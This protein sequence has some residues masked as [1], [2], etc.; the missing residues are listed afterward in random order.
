M[1]TCLELPH[2]FESK[3]SPANLNIEFRSQPYASH[4]VCAKSRSHERKKQTKWLARIGVARR[5][6]A[7][8]PFVIQLAPTVGAFRR[9][10]KRKLNAKRPLRPIKWHSLSLTGG[11]L[12]WVSYSILKIP[13][14]LKVPQ[15]NNAGVSG[16]NFIVIYLAK[17]NGAS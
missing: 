16:Q 7:T 15:A 17:T 14:V 5:K 12:L 8:P 6:I 9:N 3:M 11:S 13:S 2:C 4:N 1:G 10:K